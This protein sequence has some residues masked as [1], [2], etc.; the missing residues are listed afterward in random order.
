VCAYAGFVL[1][2]EAVGLL[3]NPGLMWPARL[4][5]VLH[6][7]S[8]AWRRLNPWAALI[9]LVSTAAFFVGV[10]GLPAHLLGPAVLFVVSGGAVVLARRPALLHL[11]GVLA[12]TVLLVRLEPMFPGWPS[13]VL[14]LV[15]IAAAWAIG[16][17]VRRLQEL[18]RENGR[19]AAELE[20][21][22]L[23]L[24]RS[25]VASERVRMA[26]E[27]HDV[28][29]HSMSVIAM[30]AGAAR[31]AVGT[32]PDRERAMLARIEGLTRGA[33]GETRR[34]VTVLRDQDDEGTG[35]RVPAPNLGRLHEL[36][37][38]VVEAGVTVDVRTQGDLDDV[39]PGASLT[40]YRVVQE[41]LTNVLRHAGPTTARLAVTVESG[42]L[43]V[44]VEDDGPVGG[45]PRTEDIDDD[46]VGGHGM[47]GMRERVALYGGSMASG[48]A[49]G[50][51]WRV[52]VR[53]PYG[54]GGR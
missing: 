47:L 35:V 17:V 22:R 34:L 7:G 9:Q 24:A 39:P 41:A 27:L 50:G 38:R 4:V 12:A 11:M 51:G 40:A 2:T 26:R 18:A 33:L 29:A 43:V 49:P 36:V 19:R 16:V 44:C 14:Y 3:E 28:L 20:R 54:E 13:L 6:G 53:I 32:D 1:A 15:V 23:E 8:V 48:P 21:A 45:A 31:L 37:S 25:A 42:L 46:S 10:L 5:A 30:H 52:E